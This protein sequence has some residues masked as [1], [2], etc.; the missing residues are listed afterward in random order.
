MRPFVRPVI[1]LLLLGWIPRVIAAQEGETYVAIYSLIVEGNRKSEAGL[2]EQAVRA[3]TEAHRQLAAFRRNNPTWNPQVI[4]FRLR[5]LEERLPDA[6]PAPVEMAAAPEIEDPGF[7]AEQRR[8]LEEELNAGREQ[9]RQLMADNGLLL[10]KLREALSARPADTDPIEV[11]KA[12]DR[13]RELEKRNTILEWRLESIDEPAGPDPDMENGEGAEPVRPDPLEDENRRLAGEV[14]SLQARLRDLEP[15]AAGTDDASARTLILKRENEQ[16]RNELARARREKRKEGWLRLGRGESREMRDL[17]A[18]LTVFEA[19]RIPWNE[20][21]RAL[22]REMDAGSGEVA[23]G[24]DAAP[25][26]ERARTW[27]REALAALEEGNHDV[28]IARARSVLGEH[29]DHVPSLC[30]LAKIHL[31]RKEFAQA[32]SLLLRAE[33]VAG[34]DARVLHMIGLLRFRQGET[35]EAVTYLSRATVLDP[36]EAAYQ[37]L[38][39]VALT[40]VGH[41]GHAE[42]ALRKAIRLDPDLAEVHVNLAIVYASQDPPSP[43]LARYHYQKALRKG[44][45]AVPRVEQLLDK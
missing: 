25:L 14:A 16:L 5:Y 10:A 8:I 6:I 24:D 22:V 30:L 40:G 2:E 45:P 39:G 1:L 38:L 21:E 28:A 13:I 37:N 4:R 35:D 17:K 42:T 32:D 20:E 7:E 23:R 29:P 33:E 34:E 12:R 36:T 9:I 26:P 44:H 27:E 43:Q 18:R 15:D 19:E 31:D 41:P 3:W 11:R